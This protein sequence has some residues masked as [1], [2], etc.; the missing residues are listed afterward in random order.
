[1]TWKL[2]RGDAGLFGCVGCVTYCLVFMFLRVSGL[3]GERM[4]ID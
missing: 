3:K 4:D 2:G 1:M